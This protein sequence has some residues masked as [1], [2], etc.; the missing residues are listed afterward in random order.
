MINYKYKIS[1]KNIGKATDML[2][3]Y[4]Y[5]YEARGDSFTSPWSKERLNNII[6]SL[7]LKIKIKELIL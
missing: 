6:E 3:A 7:D 2:Y 1:G 4:G 5:C